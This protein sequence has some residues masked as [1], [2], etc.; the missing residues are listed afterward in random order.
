MA[1]PLEEMHNLL[2]EDEGTAQQRQA[3]IKMLKVIYIPT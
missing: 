1:T 2:I 3:A